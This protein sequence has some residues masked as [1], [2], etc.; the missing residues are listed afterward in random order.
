MS[1]DLDELMKG[2]DTGEDIDFGFDIISEE[3]LNR[4]KSDSQ[5]VQKTT[6]VLESNVVG[7]SN[8]EGKLDNMLSSIAGLKS[9]LDFD[10][11]NIEGK[12]D[13]ILTRMES[14]TSTNSQ[15]LAAN[16]GSV[17]TEEKLD[18]IMEAIGDPE[19]RKAAAE[20]RIQEAIDTQTEIVDNKLKET[21]KMILPLLYMLIKPE[22]LEKN[23]IYWPNRKEVIERQIKKIL[24]VTRGE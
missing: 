8:L 10:E 6:E 14:T 21:E 1:T 11:L 18:K 24:Y 17:D 16:V 3:E 19:K 7:I 4:K 2:F 12:L 23:Y 15:L 22:N 5:V 20:Q 9:L 13:K